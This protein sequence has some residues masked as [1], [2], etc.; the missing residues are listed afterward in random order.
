MKKQNSSE[1]QQNT[2]TNNLQSKSLY[3]AKQGTIP[4][5]HKP[6][7]SKHRLIQ[8]KQ[9]PIQRRG[10]NKPSEEELFSRFTNSYKEIFMKPMLEY[11][12]QNPLAT[13]DGISRDIVVDYVIRNSSKILEL[14][15]AGKQGKEE[16]KRSE[17]G[18]YQ[19]RMT[20]FFIGNP[21]EG[22][23]ILERKVVPPDQWMGHLTGK[24]GNLHQRGGVLYIPTQDGKKIGLSIQSE[25]V[26]N[27]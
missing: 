25:V 8:A 7:P 16:D 15:D 17:V 27:L 9:K 12:T 18:R 26:Y 13:L 21:P 20:H 1:Q 2:G 6:I 22:L 5:K 14:Q 11:F 3:K 10:V 23:P 4:S 24:V 19:L